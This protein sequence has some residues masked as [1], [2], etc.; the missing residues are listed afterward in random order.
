MGDDVDVTRMMVFE[1]G[2]IGKEVLIGG[3]HMVVQ[4]VCDGHSADMLCLEIGR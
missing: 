4:G 2:R 1:G 3:S